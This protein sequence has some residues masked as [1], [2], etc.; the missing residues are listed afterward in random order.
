MAESP[1]E[2]FGFGPGAHQGLPS[3]SLTMVLT[4]G[5]KVGLALV[6]PWTP[7]RVR[8]RALLAPGAVSRH[9]DWRWSQARQGRE[10][11]SHT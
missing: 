10:S 2:P 11:T 6:Q 7:A 3:G 4:L 9:Q 8:H 5:P 1:M